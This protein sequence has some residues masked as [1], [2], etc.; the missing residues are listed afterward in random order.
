MELIGDAQVDGGHEVGPE[1]DVRLL[2]GGHTDQRHLREQLDQ[3]LEA[4][5]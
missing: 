3:L 1:L 4:R 5:H 2:V